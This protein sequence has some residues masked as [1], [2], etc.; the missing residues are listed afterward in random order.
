MK[1]LWEWGWSWISPSSSRILAGICK[2][3]HEGEAQVL[4]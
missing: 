1:E 2:A 3:L 4:C